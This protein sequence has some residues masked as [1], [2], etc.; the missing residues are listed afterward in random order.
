MRPALL[1]IA[2]AIAPAAAHAQEIPAGLVMATATAL[3]VRATMRCTNP[4]ACVEGNPLAALLYDPKHPGALIVGDAIAVGG[5]MWLGAEMRRSSR[6]TVRRLWW[7]PAATFTIAS[8][9]AW[10]R[11]ESF[12]ARCGGCS[13]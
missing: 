2:L 1:A 12:L 13:R 4:A 8:V 3:D 10:R 11:N 7:L 5:L 6:P 9:I